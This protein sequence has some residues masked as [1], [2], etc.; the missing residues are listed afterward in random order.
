M[1]EI[2]DLLDLSKDVALSACRELCDGLDKERC[3]FSFDS[4]LPREMKAV[5]DEIVEEIV[6]TRLQPTRLPVLS[7]ERGFTEGSKHS[8]LQFIIDPLDG[9][10]NFV[11]GLG[12]S[13]VS[14]ALYRK[15]EPVFGV[16]AIYPQCD[17]A[18][19]GNG[20][21]SFFNND[22]L[23]VSSISD[24]IKSVICTG[25][26]SRFRFNDFEDVSRYIQRISRFGKVRMLG[27]ASLS[28][29]KVAQGAA[30]IYME[31]EIMV[32]DVAAGLAIVEGA[33]GKLEIGPGKTPAALNV[34]ASNG[35]IQFE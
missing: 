29:L 15:Q 6:L 31:N 1:S 18:W 33:G 34:V 16:L 10:V 19:G 22:S 27:A 5:A 2:Q 12:S 7:E 8:D 35:V 24:P 13:T 32:W 20:I 3:S 9:T 26:P 28:L 30:E 14:I 11:R 17:L 21:G 25:F 4:R 23:Q